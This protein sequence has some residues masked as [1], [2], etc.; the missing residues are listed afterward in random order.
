V[1]C[2]VDIIIFHCLL[3]GQRFP[4][5]STVVT[6]IFS[7]CHS[8]TQCYVKLQMWFNADDFCLCS[9]VVTDYA[10]TEHYDN[11]V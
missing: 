9:T 2:R 3:C 10:V 4:A 5:H 6:V 7:R 11:V 8:V 1:P